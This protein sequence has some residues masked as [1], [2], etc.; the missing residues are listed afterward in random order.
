[1]RDGQSRPVD[2]AGTGS[3]T[4][5]PDVTVTRTKSFP[6]GPYSFF[7]C[8]QSA[9]V[10][11]GLGPAHYFTVIDPAAAVANSSALKM[12]R[13]TRTQLSAVPG[14]YLAIGESVTEGQ[15]A[16]SVQ[17][18]WLDLVRNALRMR[19]PVGGEGGG[20]NY[21]PAVYRVYGPDSPWTIPYST[22]TGAITP[23][24]WAGTLGY[25]SLRLS[26]G[27]TVTY[28]VNGDSA[29]IWYIGAS[30]T[31]TLTYWVDAGPRK[32]VSTT[33]AHYYVDGRVQ[34][35]S[36]GSIGTHTI[37]VQAG[38]ADIYFGGLTVYRGDRTHGVQ[39]YDAGYSGAT[40]GV[41]RADATAFHQSMAAVA[42]DVITIEL[43][44]NDY[45]RGTSPA[46][47][48]AQ[49]HDL[50]ASVKRLTKRPS[51]LLIIPYALAPTVGDSARIATYAT[52]VQQQRDL[53]AAD[54]TNVA[55]LDLSKSMPP[56]DSTG[57]GYYRS[58]ALHPNDT[59]QLKIADLVTS[60]LT[61]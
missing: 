19:Y 31:G 1:M 48:K 41:F 13:N 60:I 10:W 35:V 28:P 5:D 25:R 14:K 27:A 21:I 53:A 4:L 20:N 55:L 29:D 32:S 16:S 51:I 38:S 58:D 34:S 6:V 59:G 45:L 46:T 30:S 36:L 33:A 23:T 50:I 44:L 47:F 2:F 26:A 7:A 54:P 15:G 39:V 18:R 49:L 17:R 57:A 56:T 42:P 43:G 52:Y 11:Y 61:Q 3:L 40:V 37:T 9:G 8:V 12:W 24:Y 22:R